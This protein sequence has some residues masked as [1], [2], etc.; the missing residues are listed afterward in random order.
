[1]CVCVH[2]PAQSSLLSILEYVLLHAHLCAN[3]P[4][5]KAPQLP[6]GPRAD[7]LQAM[8]SARQLQT[9]GLQAPQPHL[10]VNRP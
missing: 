2:A 10:Q 8:S 7:R 5:F 6:A 4:S 9:R 3:I 1:M